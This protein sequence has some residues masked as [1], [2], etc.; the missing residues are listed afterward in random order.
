LLGALTARPEASHK[1]TLSN[2]VREKVKTST[3]FGRPKLVTYEWV[4]PETRRF[5]PQM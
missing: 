5:K 1:I 4:A 2:H 3:K